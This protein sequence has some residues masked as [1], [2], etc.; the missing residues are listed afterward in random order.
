MKTSIA[1]MGRTSRRCLLA[2]AACAAF[3]SSAQAQKTDF[4]NRPVTVIVAF[5]AGS[6][7]DV[8]TRMITNRLSAIWGQTVVVDNRPGGAGFVAI[9]AG[10]RT[11]A[12]GY[13]MIMLDSEHLSAVP[14]LY[15]S[16]NFDPFKLL[17]LTA[18]LFRTNFIVAVPAQSPWNSM[19]DL[20]NAAKAK[21]NSI[22]YSSWGIGSPGHLGG[23]WLDTLAGTKMSHVPFKDTG[24]MLNAVASGEVQWSFTSI[25]SSMGHYKAG[26][27]KYLAVSS[28][29]RM[30]QIPN[31]PTMTQSGGPANLELN[32]FGVFTAPKGIP[33]A[34]RDKIHADV[35]KVLAEPEIRS[36]LEGFAFE[37]LLWS[38]DEVHRVVK[39]KSDVY[40]DLV[41]KANIVL[42]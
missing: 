3:A 22:N 9:E 11:A 1:S 27:L 32:S 26:K 19:S 34:V 10:R 2:A 15:K 7:P 16:R 40:R 33:A 41:T 18:P 21:P 17:D 30:P 37:P 38:L 24:Q 12:D 5:S 13:T 28:P 8:L 29:S 20:L 23:E 4:P 39:G 31:V 35:L 14:H 42:E 25:P 6:G 36:R